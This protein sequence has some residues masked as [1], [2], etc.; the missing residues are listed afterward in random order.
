[1]R[2]WNKENGTRYGVTR[3]A[4]LTTIHLLVKGESWL[5]ISLANAQNLISASRSFQRQK[6]R[7]LPK[8]NFHS[9]P[10][11]AL[12]KLSFRIK[13]LSRSILNRAYR[14]LLK[15]SVGNRAVTNH[16]SVG[17]LFTAFSKFSNKSN[18]NPLEGGFSIWRNTVEQWNFIFCYRAESGILQVQESPSPSGV[19]VHRAEH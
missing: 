4:S 10:I 14:S 18:R 11:T 13:P 3:N 12:S 6:A 7:S 5:P 9:H 17:D 19:V 15:L 16:S 2:L 8:L 1:M